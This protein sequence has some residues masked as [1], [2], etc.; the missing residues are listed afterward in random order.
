MPVNYDTESMT[1]DF[2]AWADV[3]VNA[4]SRRKDPAGRRNA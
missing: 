1:T 2:L 4:G 3:P